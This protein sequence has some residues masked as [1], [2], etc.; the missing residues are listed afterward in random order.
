MVM[1]KGKNYISSYG[2]VVNNYNL[3]K[4]KINWI[5]KMNEIAKF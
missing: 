1:E 2:V 5:Y 4:T 3:S